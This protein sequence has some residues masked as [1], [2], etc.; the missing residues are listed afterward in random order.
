M[1]NL[2]DK[3]IRGIGSKISQDTWVDHSCPSR[4]VTGSTH[5]QCQHPQVWYCTSRLTTGLNHQ[6]NSPFSINHQKLA[7]AGLAHNTYDTVDRTEDGYSKKQQT[8]LVDSRQDF[9]LIIEV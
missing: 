9:K 6:R 2:T 4:H 5:H 8:A 7:K 3:C 1:G